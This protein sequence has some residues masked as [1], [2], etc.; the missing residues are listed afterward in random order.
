MKI[1]F[2][3]CGRFTSSLGTQQDVVIQ[4]ASMVMNILS[5]AVAG[6]AEIKR[7]GFVVVEA[8]NASKI[9]SVEKRGGLTS[10]AATENPSPTL[11]K[12]VKSDELVEI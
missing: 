11:H 3:W 5:I 1:I 9:Q 8:L 7:C 2:S 12:V 4:K 10:I 6:G